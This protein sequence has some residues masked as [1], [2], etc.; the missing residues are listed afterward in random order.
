MTQLINLVESTIS[1]KFNYLK[2][3]WKVLFF[4]GLIAGFSGFL[5]A[6]FKE[7]HYKSRL[8]FALDDASAGENS[9]SA[10][11]SQFGLSLGGGNSIFQGDNIVEILRSRRIVESVLLSVDT[12]KSR[13]YTMIEYYLNVTGR[14]NYR[15]RISSTHFPVNQ[16]RER[17]SYLQDSVLKVIYEKIVKNDLAIERPDRK[18]NI[19]EIN[20]ESPDEKLTRDFT[21]RLFQQANVFYTDLKTRKTANTLEAL[22]SRIS[23]V[24]SGLHNSISNRA[25]AMD[26]NLNTIF[27]KSQ[28]EIMK[29]RSNIELFGTAYSEMFK[30]L[31]LARFQH[32]I[33]TP[34]VQ[35]IDDARYPMEKIKAGRLKYSIVFFMIAEIIL[36]FYYLI[37]EQKE[38]YKSLNQSPS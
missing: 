11:A 23:S 27:E 36:L 1:E 18:Y 10:L 19:F 35:V 33:N 28:V 32:L 21:L 7:I 15:P 22:E 20:F 6:H 13:Q 34:I 38:K 30:N 31:E 24:R 3:K 25:D 26:A 29:E 14:D 17:F 4:V 8:T 16:G 12:F 9:F 37:K 5:I 2:R